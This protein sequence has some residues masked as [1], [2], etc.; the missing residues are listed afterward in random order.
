VDTISAIVAIAVPTVTLIAAIL[1]FGPMWRRA[2]KEKRLVLS[3]A[4]A[5]LYVA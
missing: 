5:L 1:Q 4:K 3:G 2:K